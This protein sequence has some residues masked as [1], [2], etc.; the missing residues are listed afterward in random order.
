MAF[1]LCVHLFMF[2]WVSPAPSHTTMTAVIH[3]RT[4]L[5]VDRYSYFSAHTNTDCFF[6]FKIFFLLTNTDCYSFR[7]LITGIWNQ[8]T[9]TG[10][11]KSYKTPL[12]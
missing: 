8:Y 7:R 2:G 5:G 6:F 3:T 12:E 4:I 10:E 1:L 11:K 9:F